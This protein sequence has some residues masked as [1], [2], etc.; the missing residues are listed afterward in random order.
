MTPAE[1]TLAGELDAE[2]PQTQCGQ[3][4]YP[5]CR[6]YADAMAT[7]HADINQCPPGGESAIRQLALLLNRPYKPLNPAHG[8]QRPREMA[9][10]EE[11]LC[12]GCTLCIRACPV[13]AIAGGP[14]SMHTVISDLCTGCGLCLPPCPVDC[15]SMQP[16]PSSAVFWTKDKADAARERYQR[17]QARLKG[18]DKQS[19][20][21]LNAAPPAQMRRARAIQAAFARARKLR[22]R[23]AE[24]R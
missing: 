10:I 12:I 1:K 2:L 17:R 22:A 13:D 15:I 16:A 19:P 3:C 14:R 21:A 9:A 11:R 7:G 18:G 23:Q 4:G 8:I 20:D 6:P 5:A 24:N